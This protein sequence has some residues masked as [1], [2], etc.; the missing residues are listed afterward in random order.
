MATTVAPGVYQVSPI[1]GI[2]FEI[3]ARGTG[4]A[5]SAALETRLLTFFA[6]SRMRISP[7]MMSGLDSSHDLR[8]RFIFTAGSTP[9]AAY[10][11]DAF[12]DN[13]TQIDSL[14]V[15]IDTTRPV[16]YQT[17]VQMAIDVVG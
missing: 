5:V 4:F 15:G 12:D 6:G 3:N 1:E 17:L 2:S 16:P 13:G 14:A 10:T 11:I 9:T 7:Q 8:V